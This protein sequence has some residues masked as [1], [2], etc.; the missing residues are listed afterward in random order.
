[1]IHYLCSLALKN[2]WKN[3]SAFSDWSDIMKDIIKLNKNN[4]RKM[5]QNCKLNFSKEKSG[6]YW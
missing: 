1:M 5:A 2:R 3:A 4:A 6:E